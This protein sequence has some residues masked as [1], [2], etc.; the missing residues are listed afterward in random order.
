M[1]YDM[2]YDIM[3]DIVDICDIWVNLITTSLVSQTLGIM[4]RLREII[5]FYGRKI[6]VGES[7]QCTVSEN[8]S[9][10]QPQSGC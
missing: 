1:M 8:G 6:Q 7:V 5:T 2:V 3:Y 9:P 10:S 4:V